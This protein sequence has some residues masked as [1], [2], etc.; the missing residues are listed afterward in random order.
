[1]VDMT[2]AALPGGIMADDFVGND[3]TVWAEE[4]LVS[5]LRRIYEGEV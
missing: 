4:K 1:M 5:T 3:S 2:T